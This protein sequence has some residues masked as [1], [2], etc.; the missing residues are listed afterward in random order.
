MGNLT[1]HLRPATILCLGFGNSNRMPK[2][3]L[4]ASTTESTIFTSASLSPLVVES[5]LKELHA[6]L[7][8]RIKHPIFKDYNRKQLSFL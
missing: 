4:A 5:L 6:L 8:D 1:P 7:G 3:P 2:V